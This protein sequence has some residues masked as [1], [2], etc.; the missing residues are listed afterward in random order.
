VVQGDDLMGDGVYVAAR[1]DGI[2]ESGGI[3]ITRAVHEQVRDKVDLGFNDKGEIEL[4]NI[5]RPVQ[6]SLIQGSKVG[7]QATAL[8][9]PDK[10]S[11]AGLPFQNMSGDPV[12]MD[13]P[14]DVGSPATER[15][16]T[17]ACHAV[18]QALTSMLAQPSMRLSQTGKHL[19]GPF[20]GSKRTQQAGKLYGLFAGAEYR[21]GTDRRLLMRGPDSDTHRKELFAGHG[22]P[23]CA[24]VEQLRYDSAPAPASASNSALASATLTSP[25]PLPMNR[26][27]L[28]SIIQYKGIEAPPRDQPNAF[29]PIAAV[30]ADRN[31]ACQADGLVLFLISPD[32]N[33]QRKRH[34]QAVGTR[35][36][37]SRVLS[38]LMLVAET[39]RTLR[40]VPSQTQRHTLPQRAVAE[41]SH[42]LALST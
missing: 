27:S 3:A 28:E 26:R 35:P 22:R 13:G 18:Q 7:G 17:E 23:Y 11:T 38:E 32:R 14:F 21:K 10:L 30:R 16:P 20:G 29:A 31:F 8:P 42:A 34:S 6:V 36:S 1:V 4:K 2:A 25:S 5:Q 39:G 24:A 15:Q 19:D 33:L 9:L 37:V 12:F 41:D 40:P